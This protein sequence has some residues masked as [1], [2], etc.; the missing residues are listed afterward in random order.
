MY[1]HS[2]QPWPT[3]PPPPQESKSST[4][5]AVWVVG[6]L[7]FCCLGLGIIG[8]L[9]PSKPSS[10]VAAPPTTESSETTAVAIVETVTTTEA[11]TTTATTEP[12]TTTTTESPMT[13]AERERA[14][15]AI[16]MCQ[17]IGVDG[18]G[19]NWCLLNGNEP[20]TIKMIDSG[21]GVFEAVDPM[22]SLSDER[23]QNQISALLAAQVSN[24]DF[25]YS[26]AESMASVLGAMSV[27]RDVLC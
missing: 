23:I 2:S 4:N 14:V 20:S 5:T 26:Q 1:P 3:P 22:H 15:I 10:S 19:N 6:L 25:T 21:C 24:G 27:S 16:A 17:N 13:P 9:A 8:T 7:V 12:P 11:P 18:F